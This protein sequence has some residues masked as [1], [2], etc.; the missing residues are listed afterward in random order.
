C[1]QSIAFPLSF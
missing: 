1:V